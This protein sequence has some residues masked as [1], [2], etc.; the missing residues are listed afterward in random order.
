VQVS[1]T[2]PPGEDLSLRCLSCDGV[3][4]FMHSVI[5]GVDTVEYWDRYICRGCTTPFEYRR[6]TRKLRPLV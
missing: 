2:P 4:K 5:G 6:R 3:L 1:N